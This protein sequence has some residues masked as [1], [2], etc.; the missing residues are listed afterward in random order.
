M[1]CHIL[2]AQVR[3]LVGLRVDPAQRLQVPQVIMVGQLARERHRV[4]RPN[5]RNHDHAPD[6]L[7]LRVIRRRDAIEIG[8][9]LRPQVADADERLQDVLWHDI[10]V[11]SL[12]DVLAV[13]VQV[14]RPQV[15]GR[16]AD[17][18]DTPLC[19]RRKRLLLVRRAGG[20]NHLFAV[21]VQRLGGDGCDLRH[22]LALLLKVRDLLPLDRWRCDL[23]AQNDVADLALRQRCHVDVV[24]LAVVRQDQ[25][26][27]LH[28]HV[29]PLVV[30]EAW[31]DVVRLRHGRLVRLQDHL[32]AVR[33]HM[34]CAQ[35]QDH[36][37]ERGVGRNRLQP[38]VV[39]VEQHHLW[40]RGFQDQI[41][42]LLNLHARLEGQLQLGALDHNV[43][44]VQQVDFQ[45]VQHA[46]ARH[47]D[48]LGLL[49]H[50]EGADQGRHLL[51]RLPLGQLREPLLPSPHG[52]VDDLQE[53]LP[54]AWVEDENRAVHRLCGQVA[55]EGLVDRHPV[56]VG[57]INEPDDLRTEELTVV[58][59]VQVG[60]GRLAAVELEA[61]ADPFPQHVQRRVGLHDLVHGSVQQRL[62]AREPI[63]E[64]AVQVVCQVHTH[65]N[66]CGRRVDGHVVCC[67]VQELGAA[68]SLN[69]MGVIVAPSQLHVDPVLCGGRPVETILCLREQGRLRHGPLVGCK[70][71]DICTR[72]VHL[73]GLSRVDRL[74]L[75]HLNLQRI[76]LQIKD[77]TQVHDDTLVDLL[78]Q[79]GSE[80]L[81]QRDL[82]RGDLAVHEDAG[83]VQLHLETHVHVRT[84]DGR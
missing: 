78:P 28:L 43:R 39:E 33:I 20:H 32:G 7:H 51:S 29:D 5:L 30:C 26:L 66:A 12:A 50:G 2:R 48:L 13:D 3:L 73:V 81:D 11:A 57:V 67:V 46:L 1:E 38:V 63:A 18:P 77:L 9:N 83:E 16:C 31:P 10:R 21:D 49:L 76:E 24:L 14:V 75:H 64:T 59:G 40:L 27:Q 37:A 69:I 23:H 84:V 56:H 6:L 72:G 4:V 19:A 47:N 55:L 53:E 8:G 79:V 45:G 44:E 60:L 70:Q 34:Q 58:L 68:V 62:D 74:L 22:L 15:Q 17:R 80:D 61:L 52:G 71:Q 42:E 25:V 41:T 54:R 65:Q 82:E 36:A 35:D